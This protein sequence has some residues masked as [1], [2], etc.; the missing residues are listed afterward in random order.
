MRKTKEVEA[1]LGA[2][3]LVSNYSA[4]YQVFIEFGLTMLERMKHGAE[5]HGDTSFESME[6]EKIYASACSDIVRLLAFLHRNDM[7]GFEILA[8]D[9]ANKL[10]FASYLI[11]QM[12]GDQCPD[13]S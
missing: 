6:A 13:G 2:D 7:E 12:K 10:A 8:A 1:L 3:H 9:V 5:K 11:S 4:G